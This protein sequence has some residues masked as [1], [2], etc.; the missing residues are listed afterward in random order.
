MGIVCGNITNKQFEEILEIFD[1][2]IKPLLKKKG[3]DYTGLTKAEMTAVINKLLTS[4][5]ISPDKVSDLF[6]PENTMLLN[7][8]IAEARIS[9]QQEK[10]QEIS[11]NNKLGKMSLKISQKERKKGDPINNPNTLFIFEDNLQA[12]NRVFDEKLGEVEDPGDKIALNAKEGPSLLRTN[13]NG[14]VNSNAVGFV[15]RKQLQDKDGHFLKEEG[16][17]QDTDADMQL[18]LD[19]NARV[20]VKILQAV[21]DENSPFKTLLMPEF[22]GSQK[23]GMPK[24]FAYALST[25]LY[26]NL[27]VV[28]QVYLNED[29]KTYRIKILQE[30]DT[31]Y[32][33]EQEKQENAAKINKKAQETID[34]LNSRRPQIES[35]YVDP[36]DQSLLSRVFPN[37]EQRIARV[38]FISERF[39]AALTKAIKTV[40]KNLEKLGES[41]DEYQQMLWE[42]LNKGNT[43]EQ[44]LFALKEI[45]INDKPLAIYLLE[46][47]RD[48]L[49][50]IVAYTSKVKDKQGNIID[51]TND[52]IEQIL[53]GILNGQY[54]VSEED[55]EGIN[56]IID[57]LLNP[58]DLNL[59][60]KFWEEM[61][62]KGIDMTSERGYKRAKAVAAD[63]A[64]YLRQ[65][66][67]KMI[68]MQY[69]DVFNALCEEAAYELEFNENIRFTFKSIPT[70]TPIDLNKSLE[71]RDSSDEEVD[72]NIDEKLKE[73]ANKEGYM[74]KYKLLDPA[75]TLSIK[76]KVLLGSLYKR[77]LRNPSCYVFNDI[78]ER[79]R[80]D[81]LTAYRIIQEEFAEMHSVADFNATLQKTVEK[82]PFMEDLRDK[83]IF[84]PNNPKAF[85]VQLRNE[86]FTTVRKVV[87]P[88]GMVTENGLIKRLNTTSSSE[89]LL[90]QVTKS[91]DGCLVL[92]SCSIYT[93]T[94]E[95]NMP[96]LFTLRRLF[97]IPKDTTEDNSKENREKKRQNVYMQAPLSFVLRVLHQFDRGEGKVKSI[98]QALQILAGN[99]EYSSHK[100]ADLESLLQNIGVD[101]S[102]INLSSMFGEF[103]YM[104]DEEL[105]EV[106]TLDDLKQVISN[107][108]LDDIMNTL[109]AI[110]NIIVGHD[111]KKLQQGDNLVSKFQ[112]SYLKLGGR[113]AMRDNSYTAMTFRHMGTTRATYAAPDFISDIVG[114]VSDTKHIERTN[115]W[116]EDNYGMFKFYKKN[117]AWTNGI[118]EDF[119]YQNPDGSYP[120]RE[121]FSYLNMLSY[122]GNN[123]NKNSIQNIDQQ[124]L[125]K[126]LI[127]SFY[128]AGNMGGQEFG[129]YRCPLFSDVDASVL[130]KLRRVSEQKDPNY[131][132][133]ILNKLVDTL[134]QEVDRINDVQDSKSNPNT[135]TIE[136]YNDEK[137]N[138]TKFQY[139]PE[140]NSRK[141]E[142]LDICK[143]KPTETATEFVKRRN[144]QLKAILKEIVE[145]KVERFKETVGQDTAIEIY[146]NLNSEKEEQ[147]NKEKTVE[148]TLEEGVVKENSVK[149]LNGQEIKLAKANR[150]LEEFY[151]NDFYMQ[152]QIQQLLGG[153]LAFYKNFID[154]VK[155]NKQAYACGEKL[156]ALETNDLGETLGKLKERTIYLEDSTVISNTFEK[157][158]QLVDSA[159]LSDSDRS[160][161]KF[162]LASYKN[163]TAT[164]GQSFR[165]LDSFKKIFMA[166]GLWND[167]MEVVFTHIK[168]GKVTGNDIAALWNSLKP[169]YMGME[170]IKNGDRVEKVVT[171]HKN[172]EYMLTA[173]Y[174]VL[175]TALNTSPRLR[176]LQRWMEQ[177]NIDVVHF[178]SVVK[179]GFNSPFNI[180]YNTIKYNKD[181][182][183]NQVTILGNTFKG[184]IED[185]V[186]TLKD[187]LEEGKVNQEEFD[188]AIK[189]YDFTTED[190]VVEQM[191]QQF[192]EGVAKSAPMIKEFDMENYMI[193][194]PSGNHLIDSESIFGSQI[195]NII[196]ADI[197]AE[198]FYIE[199]KIGNEVKKLNREEA[200]RFYN[201]LFV[202]NM[203]DAFSDISDEFTDIYSLQ[204]A[205]QEQMRGNPKYGKDVQEALQIVKDEY[206]TRFNLPF[207]SPNLN[208]KIEELVL[209]TFK[210]RI[211]RHKINGG[212][213]VLV[214]NFGLHDDLHVVYNDENDKS[215]GIKY[216]EA[217][218][219]ATYSSMYKDFLVDKGEYQ[220]IDFD[221]M[222]KS[223]GKHADDLLKII[224]YRIPTEDKYSIM[225]I[226]VMG[227]M[228][229]T[230]GTT[231]MLPADIITMS[232]TD[233]DID[234]LFLM[235]KEFERIYAS[236]DLRDVYH[237]YIDEK[238]KNG[239]ITE[240]Q[241]N[242]YKR[243]L[244]YSPTGYTEETIDQL[245]DRSSFFEEFYNSVG[246]EHSL[247]EVQYKPIRLNTTKKGV[248][249]SMDEISQQEGVPKQRRIAAR[250]NALIDIIFQTLNNKEISKLMMSPGNFKRVE[251][252]SREA[253][254]RKDK[255]ALKK[256]IEVYADRIKKVG[257][258]N[259]FQ[260]LTT[261]QLEEF[262]DKYATPVS[263]L[264]IVDYTIM[265]KNLMDG[266]ALIGIFAINSADHYK[267][268]FAPLTINENFQFKVNG[269]TI[270]K[271]DLVYSVLSGERIGRLNA[272]YQAAS[273]D[274]GKN[275]VLGDIGANTETANRI[276]LLSRIGFSISDVAILNTCDDFVNSMR[277]QLDDM[278]LPAANTFDLDMSRIL[279][280]ITLYNVDRNAFDTKMKDINEATYVAMF[281]RFMDN[282]NTL[283]DTLHQITAVTRSDSTNGALGVNIPTVIQQYFKAQDFMDFA[284]DR[285]CPIQ[286]MDKIINTSLEAVN[287]EHIREQLMETPIPRLQAAYTL[288]IKSAI[289]LCQQVFPQLNKTPLAGFNFLR[290]SIGNTMTS[291]RYNTTVRNYVSELITALLTQNSQFATNDDMSIMDKRNYYIH[292]FPLK[293]KYFLQEKDEN[294]NLK[295]QDLL[296][297]NIINRMTNKSGKGIKFRNVGKIG[298]HARKHFIEE[299]NYLLYH[300]DGEV[301]KFAEDLF[302]YSFFDNGFQFGH[303]NFGIFFTTKYFNSMYQFTSSLLQ[304]NQSL[305]SDHFDIYNYTYQFILNHPD[306]IKNFRTPTLRKTYTID[307]DKV[308]PVVL[309]AFNSG[310]QGTGAPFMFIRLGKTVYIKKIDDKNQIYYEKYNY[311][312]TGIPF[313]DMNSKFYEID[314]TKLKERGE[315]KDVEAAKAILK[316]AAQKEKQNE[317]NTEN[318]KEDKI[319]DSGVNDT[320]DTLESPSFNEE[321]E[322]DIEDP[323]VNDEEKDIHDSQYN[324]QSEK[325]IEDPGYFGD[326]T[327]EENEP[328]VP[329]YMGDAEG[330]RDIDD[331]TELF[332]R[333]VKSLNSVNDS[334]QDIQDPG[335]NESEN[336]PN[337]P[338]NLDD[339]DTTNDQDI[340]MC[341]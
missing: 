93:E 149:S 180:N 329:T 268:Q 273:P 128:N 232:G 326:M 264:D 187:L 16:L 10:E 12:S 14:E 80:M 78:G 323:G 243:E 53:P 318:S 148:E 111:G 324:E 110:R 112:S 89:D 131:K 13:N 130:L 305:L 231:I 91:Y 256:F 255:E 317:E 334:D 279:E 120:F 254:I 292:D 325:D 248:P 336:E 70:A 106:K 73:N 316:K 223:L 217:Y 246:W 322:K 189:K 290:N 289:T 22:I 266:N 215:K 20:I 28:S 291:G 9:K 306:L 160:M 307:K 117:G 174:S 173:L 38:N 166:K 103:L 258:Y 33:T 260:E 138:G 338:D 143:N 74:V 71:N 50:S 341:E 165:R 205:L 276:G 207:D 313:Y 30:K 269:I 265:H 199:I 59:G 335:V 230:A 132:D 163:I 262:Y 161:I 208:N 294:G 95:I 184:S 144:S 64:R 127:Y 331:N 284:S 240:E 253:R 37:I 5:Q 190:Q 35:V 82:Y 140:L 192:S 221:K 298:D 177:N 51:V 222:K 44:R 288:G 36:N 155:R 339:F 261:K 135:V 83:F 29:K 314:Y 340:T 172:S 245:I 229:V 56:I 259:V 275:P 181:L 210:N 303:N 244:S 270:N 162:V 147:E 25:L 40:M 88:Y 308:I 41:R 6:K 156:Y 312:N 79:V 63:R 320:E 7:N 85:D 219:P 249:M 3:V 226:K 228:P 169:F 175:N 239:E 92:G 319:N 179:E 167:N 134:L 299:L 171:Q 225:P 32:K 136:F 104:S 139:F 236:A 45:K 257:I 113:L 176:G 304:G 250:N 277:D 108:Q 107:D 178:H 99:T 216:I 42:G 19:A 96:N 133:T 1:E 105:E 238:I 286:G 280:Y 198:G 209:S 263:P 242:K 309:P 115:Q 67:T 159:S 31:S 272:E 220:I 151:Y 191:N 8:A 102:K 123:K 311:N 49:G 126:G 204:K 100:N 47:Q 285:N 251:H 252:A 194:Q 310:V 301:R 69:G 315:V 137:S 235:I 213:A 154:F 77:D 39:S 158:Q 94:G 122:M 11:K 76:M 295:H 146:D 58:K 48:Y 90:E 233:F 24:R 185:Y 211:Q 43:A 237:N 218:L 54:D 97:T 109:D 101:T 183:N 98:I 278:K 18:F 197:P 302:M 26:E 182:S 4:R 62:S 72:D 206:G 274:N 145:E 300:P 150:L 65:E 203:L 2:R 224:G 200:I 125:I 333:T 332:Q 118:L 121:G 157:L 330:S 27:G 75:K 21:Q 124:T 142:I 114:I 195:Q 66:Y 17:F 84:N 196:M 141:Q 281:V 337:L 287:N 283:A 87:V 129:Y 152:S 297:L 116:L 201:N 241:G 23:N 193:V 60:V 234:K 282:I 227:F 202:D 188:E 168:E 153:D 271:I 186:E 293:Y 212:N 328:D 81:A 119:F 61:S 46:K 68:S 296:G 214:S 267:L 55:E 15:V 170:A 247:D 164:D 327:D 52:N 57:S 321:S 34:T 86:F